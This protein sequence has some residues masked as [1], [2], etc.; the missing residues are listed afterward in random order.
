MCGSNPTGVTKFFG[1]NSCS[2]LALLNGHVGKSPDGIVAELAD[3][4]RRPTSFVAL[5]L[6]GLERVVDRRVHFLQRNSDGDVHDDSGTSGEIFSLDGGYTQWADPDSSAGRG[7]FLVSHE[8]F[9]TLDLQ[10]LELPDE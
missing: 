6:K 7:W 1:E 10:T 2:K 4:I 3:P 9:Q 8:S 5:G